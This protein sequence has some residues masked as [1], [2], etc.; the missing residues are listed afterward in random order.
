[1]L[2]YCHDC[3]VLIVVVVYFSMYIHTIVDKQYNKTLYT[4]R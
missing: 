4:L 3:M 2:L 1:M